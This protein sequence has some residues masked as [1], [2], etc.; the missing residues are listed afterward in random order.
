MNVCQTKIAFARP[1]AA[2]AAAE[3]VNR[4][5]RKR[6]AHHAPARV[7]RCDECG[8]FHL[9]TEHKKPKS[10]RPFA[11]IFED[12]E[13]SFDLNSAKAKLSEKFNGAIV[14]AALSDSVTHELGAQPPKLTVTQLISAL[15]AKSKDGVVSVSSALARRILDECNFAGQ[16]KIQRA[17]VQR[18]LRRFNSGIWDAR[19]STI[20]LARTP[21]GKLH[22]VNGQHRLTAIA[23]NGSAKPTM[24]VVVDARDDQHV[25][26]MYAAFDE[27]GSSRNDAEFITGAGVG[28]TL[29][30][31][32][33]I[34]AALF[35]AMPL[36]LNNLEPTGR[37]DE[38]KECRERDVRIA[39]IS[40][41]K[42]EASIY[43]GIMRSCEPWMRGRLLSQSVMGVALYTLR[44]QLK[45]A[46]EFWGGLAANDGLKRNDPRARLLADFHSRAANSGNIRQG[47]QRVALAWNA[48]YEGR[49][50]KIIRC[51]DN[52]AITIKGTPKK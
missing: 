4:R 16:R 1:V 15:L 23:E 22:N 40:E 8:Q 32:P 43:A 12:I 26:Q 18:H 36:L 7:Y 31:P 47:V 33:Q 38:S 9:F 42:K 48:F 49:D 24:I 51:H 50:L 10:A 30:L 20:T 19:L 13:M 5:D 46:Q 17:R 39:H 14:S 28:K 35:R 45:M 25:C 41:W 29:S 6:H 21:D 11:D 2:Y 34:T 37:R 52:G 27:P 3:E 44:H